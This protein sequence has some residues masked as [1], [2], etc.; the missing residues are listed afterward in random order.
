VTE[1]TTTSAR[2]KFEVWIAFWA[3]PAAAINSDVVLPLAEDIVGYWPGVPEPVRGRRNFI[4]KITELLQAV[5]DLRVEL[6][7]SADNGDAIFIHYIVRGTVASGAFES[8]G[9]DRLVVRNGIVV[10]NLIRYDSEALKAALA[11]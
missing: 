9:I 7:D 11:A 5:P 2:F 6:V 4:A 8:H 1:Q 10:E 3:N